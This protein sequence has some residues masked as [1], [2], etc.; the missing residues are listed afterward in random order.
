MKQTGHSSLAIVLTSVPA[1][2]WG[3]TR[4]RRLTQDGPAEGL[5]I[6]VP[7]VSTRVKN[8]PTVLLV[9]QAQTTES[10]KVYDK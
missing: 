8:C 2:G 7:C 3:Q 4:G 10:V 6:R 9:T 1:S 5:G